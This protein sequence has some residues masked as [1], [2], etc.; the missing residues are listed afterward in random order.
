[1]PCCDWETFEYA[2]LEA[3]SRKGAGETLIDWKLAKMDWKRHH[4]TGGEAAT[5]QL[6]ELAMEADY[7]WL[8][9][10]NKKRGGDGGLAVGQLPQPIL[11]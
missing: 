11:L 7:L 2:F 9:K 6:R 4:C 5:M 10:F 8:A 1:M 3:W